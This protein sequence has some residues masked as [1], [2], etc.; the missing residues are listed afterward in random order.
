MTNSFL[1]SLIL[2]S[3]YVGFAIGI[4]LGFWF[5]MRQTPERRWH[6]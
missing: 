4:L 5:G 1:L 6:D 2:V 3:A